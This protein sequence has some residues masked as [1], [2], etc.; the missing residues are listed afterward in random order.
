MALMIRHKLVADTSCCL[1][2][3]FFCFLGLASYTANF[4]SFLLMNNLHKGIQGLDDA[5]SKDV[6]ICVASAAT[7]ALIAA[8]PKLRSLLVHQDSHHAAVNA[9]HAGNCGALFLPTVEL[10]RAYAAVPPYNQHGD[11]GHCSLRRV[12]DVVL[13]IP[14]AMPIR[15]DLDHSL[16]YVWSREKFKGE[17][18]RIEQ[19][20][21]IPRS[22]CLEQE[23]LKKGTSP[24]TVGDLSGGFLIMAIA[25]IVSI[26]LHFLSKSDCE[27]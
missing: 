20:Y 9:F 7:D 10:A 11:S 6:N 19:N 4:T 21:P 25:F 27:F 24:M 8:Y 26:V 1:A 17:L 12:G 5:I 23:W 3:A 13:A 14:T 16:S 22:N 15:R 2:L 18:N